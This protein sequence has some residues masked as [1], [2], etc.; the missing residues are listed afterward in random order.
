MNFGFDSIILWSNRGEMRTVRFERDRVNILTGESHTGKSALL[1]IIDYCF[2]ASSQKIPYSVINENVSWYGLEFYINDKSYFIARRS[3]GTGSVSP[4]YYFSSVGKIPQLPESNISEADL[5][6]LLESEFGIDEKVTIAYGGSALRA[7]SKVSFRYFFL[8]NTISEDIITSKTI[9]FDKQ[10]EER[11]REALPR[12]FDM[13]LGIDDVENI[14]IRE[15]RDILEREISRKL[16]KITTLQGKK[17]TFDEELREIISASAQYGFVNPETQ[18]VSAESIKKALN[19]AAE[20]KNFVQNGFYEDLLTQLLVIDRKLGKLRAFTSEHKAYK[21][22]LK[23]IKDSLLPIDEIIKQSS[24][25]AKSDIFDE[26]ISGLK[27]DLAK[28]KELTINKTPVDGQISNMI[29]DLELEKSRLQ[30]ELAKAPSVTKNFVDDREK[31]IFLGEALAKLKLLG[32][33]SEQNVVS[34]DD[35][36][37]LQSQLDSYVVRDIE[38]SRNTAISLINEISK[39]LLSETGNAL[40]NYSDYLPEFSYKEK[41]LRMRRPKTNIVE[42]LG[43]SSNHMFLHLIQFLALHEAAISQ[44]SSFVPRFLIIDQPSRPYYPGEKV[45]NGVVLKS[46][47]SKMVEIAFLLL[48]KFSERIQ[49]VYGIGFQIIVLEH[50]P[51][52]DFEKIPNI[53]ILPEFTEEDGLIPQ[54]WI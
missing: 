53:N 21:N 6:A 3:P 10:S 34:T 41:R 27:Q 47:D 8:F 46:S 2:L 30:E 35:I 19:E 9:F 36:E 4:D 48:S 40:A 32:S 14:A 50:V 11:Y 37:S 51:K 24:R 49:R 26:L 33:D 52:K 12:I 25:I 44:K 39:E 15:K 7:G 31:W 17:E 43:S 1:D 5:K 23:G 18:E 13:A 54:S 38:E 42:D 22:S 20:P 16:R 45:K 28:I 29:R